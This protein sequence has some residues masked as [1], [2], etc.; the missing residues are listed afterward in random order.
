MKENRPGVVAHYTND[1][2]YSR[3]APGV[4]E[5]LRRRNPL[6]ESGGRSSKHHQWLTAEIGHP[7][8]SNHL[9]AVIAIMKISSNWT[10][11]H[12]SLTKAFPRLGDHV[13]MELG[14]D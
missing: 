6:K 9:H 13:E 4:L 12:R 3:L 5:E 2:V 14:D 1:V 10:Q 11:F 7:G 8:L